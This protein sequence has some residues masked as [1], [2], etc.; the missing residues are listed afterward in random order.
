MKNIL[1]VLVVLNVLFLSNAGF[2][3]AAFQLSDDQKILLDTLPADQRE[4]VM[5]KMRQSSSMQQ[6]LKQTFEEYQT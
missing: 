4:S 3:E 5:M 1:F 6:D 2:S